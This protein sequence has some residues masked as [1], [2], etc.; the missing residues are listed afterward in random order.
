MEKQN[1][2]WN[3]LVKKDNGTASA[4]ELSELEKLLSAHP[5]IQ[6]LINDLD[7]FWWVVDNQSESDEMKAMSDANRLLAEMKTDLSKEKPVRGNLLSVRKFMSVAAVILTLLCVATIIYF[8]MVRSDKNINIVRTKNGS[9]TEITLPDG[10]FVRLNGGSVL[11][12]PEHFNHVANREVTVC[13]EAYF[14][15]KHD[16]S[17]PFIIH[18]QY[19]DIRDLG[20]VFNV[21]AYPNEPSEATLI[22]GSI[23][24]NIK[25]KPETVLRLRPQEKV[26]YSAGS[27]LNAPAKG[28]YPSEDKATLKVSKIAPIVG[29]KGD[30]IVPETAWTQNQL[31]FSSE[32]FK[33]LAGRMER[34]FNVNF[35]FLSEQVAQFKFT[36]IFQ[37]ETLEESLRELQLSRPF[38]FKVTGDS[39]IITESGIESQ[40]VNNE[41][42]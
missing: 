28:K 23:E 29:N 15:V 40:S 13:G 3:L 31:V 6:G 19:L 20:T 12:Y 1:R 17:H 11:Q 41:L 7:R 4:A 35:R 33:T 42:N 25:N 21:R 36:G 2:I 32:S 27:S 5:D 34:W 16:P 26:V 18:T 10:S 39:V 38:A 37:G 14:E 30:L 24:V 9:K 8:L 22:S